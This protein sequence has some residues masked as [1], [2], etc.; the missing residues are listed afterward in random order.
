VYLKITI[1][2][3]LSVSL[4]AS[5]VAESSVRFGVE[6]AAALLEANQDLT[7]TESEVGELTEALNVL[8]AFAPDTRL[9]LDIPAP[10]TETISLSVQAELDYRS[11]YAQFKHLVDGR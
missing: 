1:C 9:I 2:S 3:L 4:L 11:A 5:T 10:V 8:V 7:A 6:H